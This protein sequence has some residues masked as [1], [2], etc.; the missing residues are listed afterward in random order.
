MLLAKVMALQPWAD[1]AVVKGKLDAALDELLGPKTAA[2]EQPLEK[3]KKK[4][5]VHD[6]RL[7]HVHER[8]PAIANCG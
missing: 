7:Q 1:G 3:K 5:G 6:V 4:V 2:D 8:Q